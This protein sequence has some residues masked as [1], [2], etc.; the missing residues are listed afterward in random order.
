MQ[1]EDKNLRTIAQELRFIGRHVQ[2][3]EGV[4]GPDF[5]AVDEIAMA[6]NSALRAL[7]EYKLSL[8]SVSAEL[9]LDAFLVTT[10]ELLPTTREA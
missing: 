8:Q 10:F 2:T 5:E 4:G 3:I 9:E 1:T 7:N 6:V